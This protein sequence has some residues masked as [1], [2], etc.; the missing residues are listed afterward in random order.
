MW[1]PL[2]MVIALTLFVSW[3]IK[4]VPVVMMLVY[5]LIV[6]VDAICRPFLAR[7]FFVNLLFWCPVCCV[8]SY[9]ATRFDLRRGR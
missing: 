1:P 5:C 8:L 4:R 9:F 7:H 2:L 6:I 3:Q